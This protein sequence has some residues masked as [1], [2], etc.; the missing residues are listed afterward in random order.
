M[1][2]FQSDFFPP[3]IDV[4]VVS[5]AQFLDGQIKDMSIQVFGHV[6]FPFLLKVQRFSPPWCDL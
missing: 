3:E 2:L 1:V 5:A 4:A 6:G